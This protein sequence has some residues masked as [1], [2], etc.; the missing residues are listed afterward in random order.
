MAGVDGRQSEAS[1]AQLEDLAKLLQENVCPR[2]G[3]E[4]QAEGGA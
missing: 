2:I 4:K 1:G 3:S